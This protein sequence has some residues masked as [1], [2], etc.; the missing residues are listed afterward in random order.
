MGIKTIVSQEY[1]HVPKMRL[2]L[3]FDKIRICCNVDCTFMLLYST[4]TK[5]LT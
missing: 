4:N 2:Q 3:K 5:H 1:K